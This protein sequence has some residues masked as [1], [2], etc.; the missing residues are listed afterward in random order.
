MPA[1][2]LTQFFSEAG[3]PGSSIGR[4]GLNGLSGSSTMEPGS[5]L[6]G[7][8]MGISFGS[9]GGCF[10]S[11]AAFRAISTYMAG[12]GCKAPAFIC[13]G[14]VMWSAEEVGAFSVSVRRRHL[15]YLRV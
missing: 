14:N 2:S 13:A 9:T 11:L 10:G 3:L 8:L 5:S 15:L 6:P 12:S 7:S 1:K 4:C